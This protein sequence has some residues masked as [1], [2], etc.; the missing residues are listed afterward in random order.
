MNELKLIARK[1]GQIQAVLSSLQSQR[2]VE[3]YNRVNRY[4]DKLAEI[5]KESSLLGKS[6]SNNWLEAADICTDRIN[7]LLSDNSHSIHKVKELTS[8]KRN[9]VPSLRV[10][11]E[12]IQQAF[13]SQRLTMRW[14]TGWQI[15]LNPRWTGRGRR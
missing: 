15:V 4:S 11:A 13:S 10:F 3:I 8:I 1:T 5:T 12:E 6:L 14:P 2:Y 9:E 7:R